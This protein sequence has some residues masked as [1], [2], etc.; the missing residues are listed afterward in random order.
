MS[1]KKIS[2]MVYIALLG[3]LYT[4][5]TILVAPIGFGAIQFRISEVF[6]LFAI[7]SPFSVVAITFGCFF[8][9]LIGM[10]MGQTMLIDVVIGPLATLIAGILSY[11]LRNI[12]IKQIPLL[13]ALMPVIVNGLMI[14]T[15]LTFVL[16]FTVPTLIFNIVSVGIGELIVCVFVGL[17][18]INIIEGRELDHKLF[19]SDR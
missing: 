19:F 13:S 12:R 11:F 1:H 2:V 16:G 5:M 3:A 4:I 15:M 6:T 17:P 9:N 14:G 10:F 18:L 8:S 7:F